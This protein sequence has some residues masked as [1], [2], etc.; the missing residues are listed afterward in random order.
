MR[1]LLPTIFMI[2]RLF[3]FGF[4]ICLSVSGFSQGPI[5][6]YELKWGLNRAFLTTG[7]LRVTTLSNQLLVNFSP[8]FG[9]LGTLNLAHK[10]HF[11]ENRLINN[12]D[13]PPIL[14][15]NDDY[16]WIDLEPRLAQTT[17]VHVDLGLQFRPIIGERFQLGISAG[18][19]LGYV[20]YVRPVLLALGGFQ[21]LLSNT[22]DNVE[23]IQYDHTRGLTPGGHGRLTA[24][25]FATEYLTFGAQAGATFFANG[26]FI[27]VLG[28]N[29]GIKLR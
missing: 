8:R 7:D 24:D 22:P 19:S 2:Q 14:I 26:D 4:A 21:G 27:Y 6:R 25:F 29:T 13:F 15:V 11:P 10:A 5:H 28:L 3:L 23:L 12:P 17:I 16:N 20:R 18:P 9:L 1:N